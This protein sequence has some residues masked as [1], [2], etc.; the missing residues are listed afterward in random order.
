[1]G[2]KIGCILL[3]HV[4]IEIIPNITKLSHLDFVKW[5]RKEGKHKDGPEDDFNNV[6]QK[7]G[8][9]IQTLT[10]VGRGKHPTQIR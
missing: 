3:A 1:M 10:W 4:I 5:M 6:I 9:M 7:H 2:E 8:M